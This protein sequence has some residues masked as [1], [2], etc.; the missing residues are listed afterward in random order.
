MAAALTAFAFHTATNYCRYNIQLSFATFSL[1]RAH[2][3]LKC[4][5]LDVAHSVLDRRECLREG[6]NDFAAGD[7]F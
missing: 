4:H 7:L 2:R 6:R 5:S 3:D 1:V